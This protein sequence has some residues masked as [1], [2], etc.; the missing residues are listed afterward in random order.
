M[1]STR[2]RDGDVTR[3]ARLARTRWKLLTHSAVA[4]KAFPL[5]VVMFAVLVVD[6]L[7]VCVGDVMSAGRLAVDVFREVEREKEP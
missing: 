4:W 3:P 1:L 6:V 2:Q 7:M 5:L